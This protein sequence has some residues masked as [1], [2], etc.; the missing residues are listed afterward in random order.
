MMMPTRF[1]LVRHATCAQTEE[2]LFGRSVDAPLDAR[3]VCQAETV[4]GRLRTESVLRVESSPR[5]RALQTAGRI[6]ATCGRGLRTEPALDEVDYGRWGGQRF[7][8]LEADPAWRFWNGSRASAVTPAGVRIADVQARALAH[9][10]VLAGAHPGGSLVLV[11]H[12]EIVRCIVL[13]AL[14]RPLDEYWSVDVP[15]AS[16][17]I[18]HW[19]SGRLRLDA[20]EERKSAA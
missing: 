2:V 11:T 13:A 15:P 14:G 12:A 1:L 3:G 6:A 19:N 10:D 7:E 17:T 9:L 8:A 18:I 16:L 4:A 5:L 20:E